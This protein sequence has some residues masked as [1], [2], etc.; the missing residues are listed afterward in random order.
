MKH[1]STIYIQGLI[2]ILLLTFTGCRQQHSKPDKIS[3]ADSLS[4][5]LNFATQIKH[6]KGL[7]ISVWQKGYKSVIITN[8]VNPKDTLA[9]YILGESPLPSNMQ[10]Q[11]HPESIFIQLPLN[12]IVC[13]SATYVGGLDILGYAHRIVGGI[14]VEKYYGPEIRKHVS[15]GQIQNVGQGMEVNNELII[16]RRPDLILHSQYDFRSRRGGLKESGISMVLVNEWQEETLLGRA[17][18][19]KLF[20]E[21]MGCAARADSIFNGIEADYMMTAQMPAPE[22]KKTVLHGQE[23]QGAW[24][25]PSGNSYAA[26][27]LHQVGAVYNAPQNVDK[28]TP[29]STEQ[30]LHIHRNDD[31][32]FMWGITGV[33]NL[34][35]LKRTNPK[36]AYFK[37]FETGNIYMNDKRSSKEGGNDFWESGIYRPD[38]LLKD[39]RKAIY[40]ETLPGYEITY[41][42]KIEH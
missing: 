32:W 20:G 25:L 18:W 17:E 39:F 26:N 10:E 29:L 8:P 35:D 30:V 19:L 27:A 13:L 7:R 16:A 41:W 42:R 6:A 5:S 36:Y 2:F 4:G 14:D 12:C 23:F 37:A 3:G 22:T 24:Y 34:D 1:N 33:K 31:V 40:P 15:E 28:K 11:A 21:L 9:R 38:L